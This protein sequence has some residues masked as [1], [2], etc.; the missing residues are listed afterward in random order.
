MFLTGAKIALRAP[1]TTDTSPLKIFLYSSYFSPSDK[2]EW[3][4][5]ILSLNTPLNLAVICGVKLISGTNI[6]APFLFLITSFTISIYTSVLPE[7][8]TPYKR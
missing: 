6:I 5:A 2:E 4:I 8:V 1:I 7:D 3:S